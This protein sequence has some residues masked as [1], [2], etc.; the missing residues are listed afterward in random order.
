MTS[1]LNIIGVDSSQSNNISAT[2]RAGIVQK[3]WNGILKSNEDIK[4]GIPRK[5]RRARA[6]QRRKDRA[7]GQ[8]SDKKDT[9]SAGI[10]R[11]N[12]NSTAPFSSMAEDFSR[13]CNITEFVTPNTD[14]LEM[15]SKHGHC[16]SD[17]V[18]LSGLHTCGDLAPTMIRLYIENEACKV[19][20]SVGCCY[21]FIYEE[22]ITSPFQPN[23]K[24]MKVKSSDYYIFF[25]TVSFHYVYRITN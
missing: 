21:H 3:H 16:D 7:V 1:D 9:E 13:L 17:A 25:E 18:L 14:L 4:S 2:K 10:C 15:I 22:F 19:I 6:R 5:E 11:G 23:S 20:C 12:T 8:N 24:Y